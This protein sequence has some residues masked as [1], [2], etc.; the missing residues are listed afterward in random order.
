MENLVQ[1]FLDYLLLEKRYSKHT[2]AAYSI[3]VKDFLAFQM[4]HHGGVLQQADLKKIS[5]TDI[6]AWLAHRRAREL[7][8]TSLA[9]GL[10]CIKSFFRWGQKR[11]NFS[12]SALD[13]IRAPKLPSALPRPLSIADAFD[14]LEHQVGDERDVWL[15]FRDKALFTLLYGAGLRINEALSLNGSDWGG[16]TLLIKFA[17]GGKSRIVPVIDVI[18]EKVAAYRDICPYNTNGDNPL[19]VGA[20]GARMVARVAQRRLRTIRQQLGLPEDV[21]PHAFRHSFATHLLSAKG[22]LRS[23]QDLLGHASLSTTQ[24]YTKVDREWLMSV[25]KDSHPRS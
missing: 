19:F 6:R 24:R 3:D 16:K 15:D 10:S 21:T 11:G 23:L 18:C 17:K 12:N 1:Q 7:S 4:N 8:A 2:V 5:V 25:Y 9:R 22:D 14:T 13:L 20:R